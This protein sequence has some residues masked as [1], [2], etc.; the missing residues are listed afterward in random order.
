[1]DAHARSTERAPRRHLVSISMPGATP[2]EIARVREAHALAEAFLDDV[3]A[4]A[5][6]PGAMLALFLVTARDGLGER[7]GSI[8]W[9]R[10]DANAFAREVQPRTPGAPE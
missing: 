4:P 2:A 5:G 1:M 10:F 8:D 3:G 7:C 6:V 9:T